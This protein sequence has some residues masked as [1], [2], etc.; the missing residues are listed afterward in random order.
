MPAAVSESDLRS[1]L[2]RL[3]GVA[4]Q[5]AAWAAQC[6]AL[7]KAREEYEPAGRASREILDVVG[8]FIGMKEPLSRVIERV[9]AALSS[10]FDD[11][12]DGDGGDG[13]AG[14]DFGG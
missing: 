7:G 5:L 2:T 12:D 10:S 11:G 14:G 6:E 9:G 8:D 3:V 4:E 13:G 1:N